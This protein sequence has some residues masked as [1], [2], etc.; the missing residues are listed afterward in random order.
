MEV[1][2]QLFQKQLRLLTFPAVHKLQGPLLE[3][4]AQ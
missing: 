2:S 3:E 4:T 1:M